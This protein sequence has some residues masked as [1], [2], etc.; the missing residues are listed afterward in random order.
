MHAATPLSRTVAQLGD[1]RHRRRLADAILQ[2]IY[3][4]LKQIYFISRKSVLGSN[5]ERMAS[6][7]SISKNY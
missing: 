5:L 1:K 3:M 6:H 2:T 4:S 7:A